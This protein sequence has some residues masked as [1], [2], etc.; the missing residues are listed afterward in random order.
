VQQ[1]VPVERWWE[2]VV[3]LGVELAKLALLFE[4]KWVLS[5]SLDQRSQWNW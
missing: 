2:L 5:W 4:A 3:R 1:D